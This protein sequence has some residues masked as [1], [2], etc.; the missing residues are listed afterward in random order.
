MLKRS[1]YHK[2]RLLIWGKTAPEPSDKYIETVC[3][4]AVDVDGKPYRLFPIP[5][6]YLS[7]EQQFKKYQWIDAE[8]KKSTK[9][10]RL[11][12]YEIKH[13]TIKI[14][15]AIPTDDNA[16]SKRAEWMFKNN[17]WVYNS[18]E[19]LY[20]KQNLTGTSLGVVRPRQIIDIQL[21]ERSAE[22][23]KK[24]IQKV[25]DIR[26]KIDARNAQASLFYESNPTEVL[27][28]GFMQERIQ[29]HWLCENP[30]CKMHKMSVIDWELI[31][32]QRREGNDPAIAKLRSY[33]DLTK[34]DIRFFLGNLKQHPGSFIIG[35][36]W[37]PKKSIKISMF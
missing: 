36:I 10:G 23:Q 20:E 21:H 16:W 27:K 3:T 19:E 31:E 1:D 18:V 12:S 5:F 32:L 14:L 28:I 4:G 6:R 26:Q 29:I 17:T 8:I 34:Y 7:G 11:E 25:K 33:C 37:Y 24:H 15:N 13:E 2:K 30:N 22:D 35:G 9:D